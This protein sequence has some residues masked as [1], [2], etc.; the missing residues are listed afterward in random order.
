MLA[1]S[2][3]APWRVTVSMP[4]GQT[5][6]QTNRRTDDRRYITLPSGRGQRGKNCAE[7]NFV[8]G[9]TLSALAYPV[10]VHADAGIDARFSFHG[11]QH[12][13]A[14]DADQLPRLTEPRLPDKRTTRVAGA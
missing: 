9:R 5:D 8:D 7:V 6:R 1:A 3:A 12:A 4:T 14:G 2:H 11:A 10:A 13:P